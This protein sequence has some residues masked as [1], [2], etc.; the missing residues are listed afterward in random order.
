[1][2]IKEANEVKIDGVTC[3]E[4]TPQHCPLCGRPNPKIIVSVAQF[5]RLVSGNEHIQNV[6]PLLTS[7]DRESLMTGYC[8]KCWDEIMGDDEEDAD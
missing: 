8:P 6:V 5:N 3:I 7:D 4:L 2:N 1:M